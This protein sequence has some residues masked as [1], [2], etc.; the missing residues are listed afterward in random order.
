MAKET[1]KIAFTNAIL[2][3]K[4]MT[5]SEFDRDGNEVVYDLIS[6]MS[7]YAGV[8]G[9]SFSLGKSEDINGLAPDEMDE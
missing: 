3:L 6:V 8:Y 2:D 9:I 1:R 5:I 4:E 7:D